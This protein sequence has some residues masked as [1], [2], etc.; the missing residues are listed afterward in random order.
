MTVAPEIPLETAFSAI[1]MRLAG[2]VGDVASGGSVSLD[3]LND[4]V[5]R[6]CRAALII[7]GAD[8]NAIL[9]RFER[10]SRAVDWL[11]RS[12]AASEAA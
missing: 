5:E 6:L 9:A 12:L 3:G 1:E 4:E 7:P 11:R 8:R 2:A 10:L